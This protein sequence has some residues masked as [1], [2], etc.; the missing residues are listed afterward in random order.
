MGYLLFKKNKTSQRNKIESLILLVE[1]LQVDG[2]FY[3]TP[4]K[5]LKMY[6][7]R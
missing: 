7:P 1:E 5:V 6:L 3:S 2:L 4:L